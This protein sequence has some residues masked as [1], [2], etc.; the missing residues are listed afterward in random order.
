MLQTMLKYRKSFK[1]VLSTKNSYFVIFS[2][3]RQRK[4]RNVPQ[5]QNTPARSLQQVHQEIKEK[6]SQACTSKDKICQVGSLGPKGNPGPQSDPG[7]KGEK[8]AP[9]IF[10]LRG[11]VGPTGTPAQM[12]SK[13]VKEPRE[14]SM[15]WASRDLLEPVG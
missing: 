8:V 1:R 10:G 7:Y 11:P 14:L 9:G 2:G 15:T 13:D 6:L 4:R 3:Y 5:T 12:G